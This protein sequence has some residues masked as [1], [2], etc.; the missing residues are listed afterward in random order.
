MKVLLIADMEGATGVVD[1]EQCHVGGSLYREARRFIT[2]DVKAAADGALEGGAQEVIIQDM[3]GQGLNLIIEEF[4]SEKIKLSIGHPVKIYPPFHMDKHYQGVLLIGYHALT[5]VKGGV[6]THN[7]ARSMKSIH[8]NGVLVGE[9]GMEAAIAGY[10]GVPI[11]MVSG[12]LKAIEETRIL[13]QD[14]EEVVVKHGM[15]EHSALCLSPQVT[16]KM[17][18]EKAKRAVANIERFKPY[19]VSS[20]YAVK[21]EFF[22]KKSADKAS[23]I[24]GVKRINEVIVGLTGDNLPMM[25]E[26]FIGYY[27][28]WL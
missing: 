16:H 22:E 4:T 1:S 8:L 27:Q 11:I 13:I 3:H 6:L 2:S 7:Y 20:P 12:D 17:I 14:F 10:Y 28:G 23:K 24:S 21:V 18:K 15:N 26:T 19:H 25:W 5:G 9:I